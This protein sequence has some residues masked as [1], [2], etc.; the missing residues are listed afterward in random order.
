ML[1]LGCSVI[2]SIVP[3]ALL[4]RRVRSKRQIGRAVIRGDTTSAGIFAATSGVKPQKQRGP[5]QRLLR[6]SD[7]SRNSDRRATRQMLWQMLRLRSRPRIDLAQNVAKP[8]ERATRP[9]WLFQ[10]HSPGVN[11][12]RTSTE[13]DRRRPTPQKI[14]TETKASML[15]TDMAEARGKSLASAAVMSLS[16]LAGGR[17]SR[18]PKQAFV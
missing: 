14:A 6:A 13:R 5:E 18:S 10:N 9:L 2:D 3:V 1:N 15:A 17:L 11:L 12:S 7:K 16:S 8:T 4:R